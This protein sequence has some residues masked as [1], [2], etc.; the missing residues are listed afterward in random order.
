MAAV[1]SSFAINPTLWRA[2]PLAI[3]YGMWN[4]ELRYGID[5]TGTAYE[6]MVYVTGPL[7]QQDR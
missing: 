1:P 6:T 5:W 2:F 4:V 7:P 3:M